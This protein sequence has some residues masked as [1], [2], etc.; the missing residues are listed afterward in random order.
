MITSAPF[1]N[2]WHNAYGLDV[3]IVSPPHVLLIIGG[4]GVMIGTLVLIQARLNRAAESS[5]ER[6]QL[7]LAFFLVAGLALVDMLVFQMEWTF[8]PYQH[9]ATMYRA[10]AVSIPAMLCAFSVASGHRWAC[11]IVASIYTIFLLAL[12]W[13]LPF[14]PAQPKLG[15]VYT[16]V[17]HFVPNGFPLVF[18]VPAVVLDVTLRKL[19]DRPALADGARRRRQ[20]SGGLLRRAVALRD[21]PELAGGAE[22]GLRLALPR[23]HGPDRR[24]TPLTIAS[25]PSKRRQ[26]SFRASW[27]W[28]SSSHRSAPGSALLSAT[29]SGG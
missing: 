8:L 7:L 11:T 22:L 12:V 1:D 16:Q 4:M 23:L 24:P 13:I 15:P 18:I 2:W 21:L 5:A 25:F 26:P 3:K 10:L 9:S 28:A 14:F 29:G 19:A 20:L 27:P 6:G 17:T